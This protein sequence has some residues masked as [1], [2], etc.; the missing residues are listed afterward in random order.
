M[1]RLKSKRDFRVPSGARIGHVHVNVVDDY[2]ITIAEEHVEI[3]TAEASCISVFEIVK[4]FGCGHGVAIVVG[5]EWHGDEGD[6][7]APAQRHP[8]G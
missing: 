5:E 2:G 6:R 8:F 4:A 7:P 1:V 3:E